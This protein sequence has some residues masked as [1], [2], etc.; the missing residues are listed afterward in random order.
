MVKGWAGRRGT[1]ATA[2]FDELGA[3]M[4][5]ATVATIAISSPASQ[6]RSTS[7][8]SRWDMPAW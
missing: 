1:G 7:R 4:P 6:R 5:N 8:R 3:P 2:W